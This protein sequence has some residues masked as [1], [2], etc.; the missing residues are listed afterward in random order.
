MGFGT[1][2]RFGKALSQLRSSNA[3]QVRK[4]AR[5]TIKENLLKYTKVP[6]NVRADSRWMK[7]ASLKE[8]FDFLVWGFQNKSD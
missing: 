4:Q 2:P 3:A 1:L 6:R 7:R 8:V 5:T